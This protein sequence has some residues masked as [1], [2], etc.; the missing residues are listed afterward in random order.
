VRKEKKG[1]EKEK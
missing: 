1:R